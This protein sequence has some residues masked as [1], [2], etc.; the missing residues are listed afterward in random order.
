MIMMYT[1]DNLIDFLRLPVEMQK[2][3]A[4]MRNGSSSFKNIIKNN[5]TI[6]GSFNELKDEDKQ[7]VVD[8]FN[9]MQSVFDEFFGIKSEPYT[10]DDFA[11]VDITMTTNNDDDTHDDQAPVGD[12]KERPICDELL[13]ELDNIVTKDERFADLVVDKVVE[14]LRDKKEK[15]Y[16]LKAATRDTKPCVELAVP[17]FK[18]EC[19]ER[20]DVNLNKNYQLCSHIVEKTKKA[21]GSPE[22]L[23]EYNPNLSVYEFMI[24]LK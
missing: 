16:T 14:I 11:G 23:V 18:I 20:P 5:K 7:R 24:F 6:S 13:D 21:T 9:K 2:C 10:A 8:S 4:T 12:R 15:N 19:D 3:R 1:F 22:V 17:F